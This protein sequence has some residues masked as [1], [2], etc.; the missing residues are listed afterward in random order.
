MLSLSESAEV[1]GPVVGDGRE[2]RKHGCARFDREMGCRR[3]RHG[4]LG[5]SLAIGQEVA[6]KD[7]TKGAPTL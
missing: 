2:E 4:S 7:S 1:V 5:L 3:L 6:V